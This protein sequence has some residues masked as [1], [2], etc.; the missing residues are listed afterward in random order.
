MTSGRPA[1]SL[2]ASLCLLALIFSVSHVLVVTPAD[3]PTGETRSRMRGFGETFC[4]YFCA[5]AAAGVF[6]QLAALVGFNVT[7]SLTVLLALTYFVAS[8]GVRELSGSIAEARR[9]ERSVAVLQESEELFRSAF[10]YAAIGMALV[11]SKGHWLQ[12]NRSLCEILGYDETEL[13]S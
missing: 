8:I 6:T 11:S 5:V 4:A 7:L 2:I 12:V 3:E 13:L 9:I 1:V 10:D